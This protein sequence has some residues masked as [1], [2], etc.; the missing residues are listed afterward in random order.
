MPLRLR[1]HPLS[2]GA[3]ASGERR[4]TVLSG[5]ERVGLIFYEIHRPGWAQGWRWHLGVSAPP[6]DGDPVQ[7][8]EAAKAAFRQAWHDWLDRIELREP[9]AWVE[10]TTE[11]EAE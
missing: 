6:L 3:L 1:P 2:P 8:L 11:S 7:T 4:Y 10:T 5:R 9:T